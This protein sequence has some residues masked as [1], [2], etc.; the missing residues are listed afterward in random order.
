VHGRRGIGERYAGVQL[1]EDAIESA[2]QRAAKMIEDGV[3]GDDN[4][5]AILALRRAELASRI[6]RNMRSRGSVLRIVDQDDTDS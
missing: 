2:R 3:P 6:N 1:D 4:R 5:D